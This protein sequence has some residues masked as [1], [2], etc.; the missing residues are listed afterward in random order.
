VGG[1]LYIGAG[2]THDA[3]AGNDLVAE[4]APL[5]ATAERLVGNARVRAQGT[6]GGNICFAEPRSDVATV[7]IALNASLILQRGTERRTVPA[8]EFFLGPYWT[9]REPDELLLAITVPLPAPAGVYVKFQTVERPT[10]AVAAVRL[11][12]GGIRIV[13]G[14]VSDLPVWSDVASVADI[15][16]D[17]LVSRIEPVADLVGS[18]RYKRHVTGVFVRRAI[19]QLEES[20]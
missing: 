2:C 14:A 11:P 20:A 7:I 5:L 9:I 12:A 10:V 4:H 8:H 15:D 18:E 19:V 1:E 6:V 3:I 13:I 17:D 16:P